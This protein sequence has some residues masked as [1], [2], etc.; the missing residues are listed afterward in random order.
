M[1]DIGQS[2]KLEN[3]TRVTWSETLKT[4][5]GFRF[6]ARHSEFILGVIVGSTMTASGFRFHNYRLFK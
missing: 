6:F 1:S 3:D 5:T 4:M 2:L